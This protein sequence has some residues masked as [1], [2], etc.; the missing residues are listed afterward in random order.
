MILSNQPPQPVASAPS[1]AARVRRMKI[2][3]G[4]AMS[5]GLP[6][7]FIGHYAD[8]NAVSITGTLMFFVGFFGFVIARFRES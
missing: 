1:K 4:L 8:A 6:A 3:S 2:V 5:I 7:W